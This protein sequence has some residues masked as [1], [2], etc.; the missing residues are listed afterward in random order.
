[1]NNIKNNYRVLLFLDFEGVMKT[2]ADN[3]CLDENCVYW[4]EKLIS[5]NPFIGVVLSANWTK[6]RSIKEIKNKL[7]H[8]VGANVIGCL[9]E[10]NK[11]M[12]NKLLQD[13]SQTE[14]TLIEVSCFESINYLN[15]PVIR[16]DPDLGFT[17]KNY[18]EVVKKLIVGLLGETATLAKLQ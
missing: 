4:L 13:T 12:F 1:M 2:T 10:N 18:Y 3:N 11:S 15:I 8:I 6:E 14:K 7:G 9:P 17:E 16:T 5:R